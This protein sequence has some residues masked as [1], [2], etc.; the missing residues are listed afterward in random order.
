MY[1]GMFWSSA[2]L[3][4]WRTFRADDELVKVTCV[5]P[6]HLSVSESCAY[7]LATQLLLPISVSVWVRV[8]LRLGSF[9]R[10]ATT[11]SVCT[12]LF[13]TKSVSTM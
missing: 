2:L 10:Y 4:P 8:L 11:R 1:D 6:S 12:L 5:R 9:V 3:I 7:W 13:V